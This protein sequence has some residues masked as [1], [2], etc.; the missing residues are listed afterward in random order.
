MIRWREGGYRAHTRQI[1]L[2]AKNRTRQINRH[3]LVSACTPTA[4]PH[5]RE[6][7]ASHGRRAMPSARSLSQRAAAH[8]NVYLSLEGEDADV[9]IRRWVG[10]LL[11]H[12]SPLPHA[13]RALWCG[14][15]AH[16][17]PSSRQ[18]SPASPLRAGSLGCWSRGGDGWAWPGPSCCQ[19]QGRSAPPRQ[20]SRDRSQEVAT[21][22]IV[23]RS[24]WMPR[25][26]A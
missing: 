5:L 10:P 15:P 23:L 2:L 24:C 14:R 3:A 11:W 22:R 18:E 20:K 21:R 4:S 16:S 8:P 12:A 25:G 1:P 7:P 13:R 6:R 26:Q 19:P 9:L 17:S